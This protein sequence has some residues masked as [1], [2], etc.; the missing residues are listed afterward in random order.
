MSAIYRSVIAPLVERFR[1]VMGKDGRPVSAVE[2]LGLAL[3]GG[4]ARG[5]AHVGVLQVLEENQ[6]PVS[7]IAGT[8]VGSILGAAYASGLSIERLKEIC[9]KIRFKDFA[10]WKIS[11]MGLAS[12]KRMTELIF[13]SFN[14]IRFE[15]LKIPLAVVTTDLCTGEPVVFTRGSLVEPIRASCAFPGLFEPVKI[16]KYFLAD[17]GLTAPVPARAAAA[18]G[19]RHVLGVSVGFNNWHA[20]DA[21]ANMF[22]VMSRAICVAQKHRNP[23]WQRFADILL[24][25]EV[26]NI[27]WDDFDRADDAIAAGVTSARAAIPRLRELMNL[28]DPEL[29]PATAVA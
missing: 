21:P 2:G 18:L 4:F 1:Q 16:G 5:F 11:K 12:N 23:S 19:A 28:P 3:G 10:S 22:Q 20:G 14:A 29:E 15:D 7:C 9:H 24:E 6:I 8:S 17:G 13:R 25:P 26:Q 27:D